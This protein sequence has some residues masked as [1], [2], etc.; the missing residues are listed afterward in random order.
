MAT[1][2]NT[3]RIL[4]V[5]FYNDSLQRALEIIHEEGG[6]VLA[7]SGPG[8]SELGRNPNYDAALKIAD[9]NLIDS[10]Y[11]ALLW[12]KQT[13]QKLQRHSGL[14]FIEALL[15]EPEFKS[16][17][18]QLWVMPNKPQ[19]EAATRHLQK[20]GIALS[21]ENF[22]EAPFYESELVTDDKL[23]ATIRSERP[24][25]I[26]LTIAGG[27]QEVLGSWLIQNLDYKPAIICIGAAIAFLSGEQASIPTWA[28]R[29]YLGWF[30]RILQDPKTF[31]PR[32]W[33][34]QKLRKLVS[35][36]GEASPAALSPNKQ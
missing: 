34:A 20:E 26:I 10:G 23:L 3:V 21:E 15:K 25:Y 8:L 14:K 13:G 32:Y 9:I 33:K 11:L 19:R 22:Y 2:H 6:L 31:I 30:F 16:N 28:D 36:Y 7:P 5:D 17:S 35:H 27:K 4:G 18:K 29:L 12:N 24:A 1:N